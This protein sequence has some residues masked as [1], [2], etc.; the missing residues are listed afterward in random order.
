MSESQGAGLP[1]PP[2]TRREFLKRSAAAAALPALSAESP[3]PDNPKPASE[4]PQHS[5]IVLIISDQLRWDAIGAA[6]LSPMG[7]TPN[8]D[9]MARRGV[10]FQSA[11]TNQ[12]LCAPSRACLLTG[13]YPPKHGVWRNGLGLAQGAVT[14]ATVLRQAGYTANYIGK[15]HLAPHSRKE[16]PTWGPVGPEYRGGFLDF[17]EGANELELSSHPYEGDIYDAEGKPIHF[18]GT[19]RVDFLTERAVRFLRSARRPFFLVVSYLEPHF[20]NDINRFVAPKGY[21]ERYAN[22]YVPE[23][24]RPFPGDWLISLPD[25]YGCIARVDESV[26]SILRTLGELGIEQNTIVALLSDH[27]CHFR[28][29]NSEY[30]RSPHES[31]VHIPLVVQGPGFNRSLSVPELVSQV[32]VAPTLLEAV[33]VPIPDTVQGKSAMPLLARRLE[34]WRNEVYIEVTESMVGRALRTARWKYS[35][36]SPRTIK[37]AQTPSSERYVEYQMYDLFADPHE[38]VNFAGRREY[39]DIASELRQRLRARIVEAGEPKPEI[40]EAPY[41]P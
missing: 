41:Y 17:W 20:Q 1:E 40:D 3:E 34:G 16:S 25:Y 24:L 21:A 2:P 29:R 10:L 8:L 6:G 27:A 15:W 14:I 32:D 35:V 7:L 38:L 18:S 13:R 5:N 22:A 19:Y 31:S 39:R 11:I 36:V 37:P 12:P 26:G 33:G 4:K 9:G 28:T 23:D 30:K